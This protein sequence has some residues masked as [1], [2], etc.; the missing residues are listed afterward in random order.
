MLDVVVVGQR[1]DEAVAQ[2]RLADAGLAFVL[3]RSGDTDDGHIDGA[4]LLAAARHL[5][6]LQPST[7]TF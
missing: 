5:R 2:A 3:L 4:R 6:L 1:L 7:P